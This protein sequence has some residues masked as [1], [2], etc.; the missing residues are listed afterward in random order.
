MDY[1]S[2]QQHMLSVSIILQRTPR[3]SLFIQCLSTQ[4]HAKKISPI[5]MDIKPARAPIPTQWPMKEVKKMKEKRSFTSEFL[6]NTAAHVWSSNY[7]GLPFLSDFCSLVSAFF[8]LRSLSFNTLIWLT[9]EQHSSASPAHVPHQSNSAWMWENGLS[10]MTSCH[11]ISKPLPGQYKHQLASEWDGVPKHYS[12]VCLPCFNATHDTQYS[13]NEKW[14]V[15]GD[16]TG[17][18]LE[19]SAVAGK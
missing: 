7:L 2:G 13:W 8:T 11:S 6:I 16:Y 12:L 1:F 9:V 19:K 10:E 5:T 18:M 15:F 14:Q 3:R 17:R 4:H